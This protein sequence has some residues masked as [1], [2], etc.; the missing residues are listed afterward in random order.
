MQIQLRDPLVLPCGSTLPNRLVK[1][2][3]SEALGTTDNRVTEKLVRVYERWSAGGIGMNITGNVMIDRRARAEPGNV[4]IEDDRDMPLLKAWAKAGQSHGGKIWVQINHPGKQCPKGMNKETVSPSA[5]PFRKDLQMMF[6]TP[7]ALEESEILDLIQRWGR[8]ARICKEAGFDGVQIHGAHGYLISQFLSPLTNQRTDAWGGSSE[9]RRRFVLA[10]Y[11]EVRKQVGPDFPVGIKLNSAD[12]QRGGFSEKESLAVIEELT[13]RGIDLVEVSG[14]TYEAP[15]MTGATQ[16]KKDSTVQREAYF[17]DFTEKVRAR[18]RVPLMLTGGFRTV[19]GMKQALNTGAVDVIGLARS[20]AIEPE[21]PN[22]LL[23]DQ[24][25]QYPV[26]PLITGVKAVDN[27]GL[28]EIQWYTR[29]IHR[30]GKG[31]NPVPNEHPLK[32]LFFYLIE[33]SWGLFKS[34]RLRA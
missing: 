29:Q 6:A 22:R 13:E 10:V 20:I 4:V 12:F 5:V 1:A 30:M 25:A 2:A 23:A 19:G 33:S 34:R 7:R 17:I 9:N 27:S 16:P 26:K 31:K 11:D 32:V 15:V 3:M 21:L 14:G 18:C 24:E 8:T 28:L